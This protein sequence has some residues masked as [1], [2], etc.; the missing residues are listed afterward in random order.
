M[1]VGCFRALLRRAGAHTNVW[2]AGWIFLLAHYAA[3]ALPE[4][5]GPVGPFASLASLWAMQLCG[6]C[7]FCAAGNTD[8]EE[9]RFSRTFAIEIAI[10]LLLQ[11]ALYVFKLNSLTI[12]ILCSSLFLVP[13]IHLLLLPRDRS[14]AHSWLAGASALLG[15]SLLLLRGYDPLLLINLALACVFLG[16]AALLASNTQRMTRGTALMVVSLCLWGVSLPLSIPGLFGP[17]F[18]IYP[19]L[20]DLPRYCMAASM[21]ISILDDY[22]GRAERLALHDPLT[23]L[24]NRRLFEIRLDQAL[25][26]SRR[27]LTPV[28]CLVIDVDGFK[29]IN[30]TLGHPVGDGL[31][32]ALAKRLSWNLGPRDMLART[33]GDEFTAVLVEAADDYHI[34]FIAGAMMAAGCVPVSIGEH[35]INVRISIGIAVAPRDADS[36]SPLHKVADDAMYLAKRRGGSLVAFAGEEIPQIH[37]V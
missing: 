13:A 9:T 7:F 4:M 30:D 3:R 33:G 24:P 19:A 5:T 29:Q 36:S 37:A 10:P 12:E 14:K 15:V 11:S 31:L 6:L 16:A 18:A 17:T 25:E 26:E 34:R 22:V 1:F 2:F 23:G 20:W 8:T 32:Q 35:S 28:A 21:L 27:T